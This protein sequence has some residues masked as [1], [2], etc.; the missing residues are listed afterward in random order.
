MPPAHIFPSGVKGIVLVKQMINS[1]LIQQTIGIVDP[2]RIRR[3]MNQRM[4]LADLR[5]AV[6]KRNGIQKTI[7]NIS[8]HSYFPAFMLFHIQRCI[9]MEGII[10]LFI[11][12]DRN[13]KFKNLPFLH[14]KGDRL[15]FLFRTDGNEQ[16]LFVD[17]NIFFHCLLPPFHSKKI[18]CPDI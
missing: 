12:A 2:S 3:E 15:R 7:R 14:G 10:A 1:V 9:I 4:G 8:L 11:L 6:G 16:I 13:L 18:S 17:P 5:N